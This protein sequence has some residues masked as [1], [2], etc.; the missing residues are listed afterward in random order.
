MSTDNLQQ[1]EKTPARAW[2]ILAVVFFASFMAPMA[3][4]KIPP[5]ASWLIPEYGLDGVTF[6]FLMSSLSIIGMIL[7]FPAAFIC[8]RFGLKNTMLVSIGS[9]AVGTVVSVLGS[10]IEIIYIGRLIEGIGIGLI[11]VA[12]PSCISVWFPDSTR[13]LALGIWATWFPVGNVVMF[14]L[15]PVVAESFTWQT[16]FWGCAVLCVIAFILFMAVYNTPEGAEE[17]NLGD[18]TISS[19]LKY[20]KTPYIWALG[21]TF[22]VF[23]FLVLGVINTFY[24]TFLET[25]RGY[26]P[27]TAAS[28]ASVASLISI[29]TIPLA[30]FI[31]DRVHFMK[32]KY[33]I[34]ASYA[35]F[36]V[37]SLF[38]YHEG[39]GA[40][41]M[42]WTFVIMV[43]LANGLSGGVSRPM[44]PIVMGTS[45][46]AVTMGMGVLQF[47]QN[48][49]A[50]IGSPLFGWGYE[51]LGWQGA[52][53]AIFVPACAVAVIA[54]LFITTK[55]FKTADEMV[56]EAEP[57]KSNH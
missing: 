51:A 10:S 4:F 54:S 28:I 37:A 46:A 32:K 26:P 36:I 49:G 31:S 25:V 23:N 53:F 29:F 17:T 8:R 3:Q 5:L 52:N 13:G 9:L 12:A 55:K 34:A 2:L 22:F 35:L 41:A 47:M 21:V 1:K 7:A 40:D 14:N 18:I 30:G 44:A 38:A 39:E 19:S 56:A 15:A 42:M 45:V 27:T 6:G 11:G 48:L 43:G 57:N 16:V 20:L 24:N 33:I 50:V